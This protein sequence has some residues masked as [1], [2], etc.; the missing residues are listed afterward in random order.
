MA[1]KQVDKAIEHISKNV[2]KALEGL[3]WG[4]GDGALFGDMIGESSLK[5][6]ILLRSR[7]ASKVQE[8]KIKLEYGSA[9][10]SYLDREIGPDLVLE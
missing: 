2:D 6:A 10:Y 9:L 8:S 3:P 7:I 5:G 4:W 1:F